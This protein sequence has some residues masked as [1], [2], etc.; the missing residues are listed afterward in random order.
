MGE[1]EEYAAYLEQ[2]TLSKEYE[3]FLARKNYEKDMAQGGSIRKAPVDRFP[4]GSLAGGV[5]GGVAR[6]M[7]GGP[8]G[9]II[10]GVGGAVLGGG[11]QTW[12]AFGVMILMPRNPVYIPNTHR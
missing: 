1:R 4:I 10:G 6:G 2:Q 11:W 12:R 8:A 3:Q 9:A 5:V 7:V